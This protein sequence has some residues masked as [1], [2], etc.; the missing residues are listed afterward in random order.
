MRKLKRVWGTPLSFAFL[1][2]GCFHPP[3]FKPQGIPIQPAES[4]SLCQKIQERQEGIQTV[5]MLANVVIKQGDD[6]DRVR[7]VI[8]YRAPN[9]LHL[10]VLP[11]QGAYALA[12]VVQNGESVTALDTVNTR[13][14][15]GSDLGQ[16]LGQVMPALPIGFNEIVALIKGSLPNGACRLD[17]RMIQFYQDQNTFS[18]L[19]PRAG[20]LWQLR[21]SDLLLT[22]F[23][24]SDKY[25]ENVVMEGEIK[26]F[27]ETGGF[28][29]PGEVHLTSPL[30]ST[31]ADLTVTRVRVNEELGDQL[32]TVQ[33]PGDYTEVKS[34]E[35]M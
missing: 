32:F 24:V 8:V 17:N 10:E 25:S 9:S 16:V 29:L 18:V 28:L 20:S 19:L 30:V 27:S 11:V 35:E 13:V 34:K 3:L 31:E 14:W 4:A 12:L 6:V 7:Y 26:A 15:H 1:L 21:R 23:N 2:S 22:A 5:R 33:V